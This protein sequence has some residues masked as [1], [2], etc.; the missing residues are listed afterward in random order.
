MAF[1]VPPNLTAIFSPPAAAQGMAISG[2][3]TVNKDEMII[4]TAN[5]AAM[6]QQ[7]C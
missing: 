1:L 5:R 4:F 6:G 7:R 3:D 2:T